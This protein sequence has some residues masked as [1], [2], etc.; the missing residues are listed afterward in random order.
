MLSF[1]D[2]GW[3]DLTGGYKTPFDPRP[4]LHKLYLV[5]SG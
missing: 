2:A 4:S 1:D 3:D 5:I